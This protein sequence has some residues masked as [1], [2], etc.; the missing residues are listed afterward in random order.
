MIK[1]TITCDVCKEVIPK[2]KP[3]F[4]MAKQIGNDTK[5]LC[6]VCSWCVYRI[7]KEK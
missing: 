6:H 5:V 3:F 4:Q 2:N 7:A 1:T